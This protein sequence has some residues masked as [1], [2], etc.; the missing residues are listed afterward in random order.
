MRKVGYSFIQPSTRSTS[1]KE[2][3]LSTRTHPVLSS[4]CT[5]KG[6]WHCWCVSSWY[7]TSKL[8]VVN[9]K[10][11]VKYSSNC[12]SS[13]ADDEL[14]VVMQR[15]YSD[16]PAHKFIRAVNAA[17]EPAIVVATASQLNDLARFCTS[18]FESSVLTVDPTFCL[19]DFDVTLI[20]TRHLLLQSKRF[21]ESPVL[22]GPACI[23]YK[24]SFSTYVFFASTIVGQCRELEGV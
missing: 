21:K 6:W 13:I 12:T 11:K 9:F 4:T 17:P 24:K 3:C 16:D 20:T 14:F 10:K 22:V 15:A 18:S 19:G 23:H 8:Q 1:I 5:I 7:T 2:E